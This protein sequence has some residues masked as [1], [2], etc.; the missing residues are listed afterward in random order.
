MNRLDAKTRQQKA[1]YLLQTVWA[2]FLLFSMIGLGLYME[3]VMAGGLAMHIPLIFGAYLVGV[4]IL[5]LAYGKYVYKP[6]IKLFSR[7]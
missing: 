2:A 7:H 4:F 1:H 5:S 3:R 6:I